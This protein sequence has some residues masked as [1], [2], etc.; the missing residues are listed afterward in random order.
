MWVNYCLQWA[1]GWFL[2][3]ADCVKAVINIVVLR[4]CVFA[5]WPPGSRLLR[6]LLLCSS[7]TAAAAAAWGSRAVNNGTMTSPPV[8]LDQRC[9]APSV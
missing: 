8:S 5:D 4:V 7:S 9:T 2:L 1:V 6:L 3:S